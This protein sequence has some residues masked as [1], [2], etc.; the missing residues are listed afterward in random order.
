MSI[1]RVFPRRTNATPIDDLAFTTGPP[2]WAVECDEVH[3]NCT[4]T[5]DRTKAEHLADQW[6]QAGYSVKVG[7]P[8]YDDPGGPFVP[9]RYLKPGYTIT[10]RGCNNNCWFC[11][12]P[13]REGTIR[14]LPIEPGNN[15]LDS[16]LLQ[17]SDKHIKS[18]FVMLRAQT[19]IQFTGGLEAARL[20]DWHVDELLK[21]RIKTI[22]FAYDTADDYEPLLRAA[23]MLYAARFRRE[24][25][26]CYCLIGYPKDN[27]EDAL[28]RLETVVSL[29]MMPMAMLYRDKNGG[30]ENQWRKFQRIWANNV[31]VT[32]N[33]K[34]K[35][36]S[37]FK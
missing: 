16:N 9:G 19:N 8:A 34:S 3:V 36:G 30:T 29:N 13:K 22:Y 25:V 11:S 2:L 27:M 31:I 37:Y 14:E 33:N 6:V 28:K 21:L 10:S 23:K 24:N 17:C 12:V 32:S 26:K 35:F 7:G 5:Y 20:K 1:V 18:V 15:I 4:F